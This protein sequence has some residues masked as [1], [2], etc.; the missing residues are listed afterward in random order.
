MMQTMRK[1]AK[2]IFFFVLVTFV[3]FMAYSGIVTS[4]ASKNRAQGGG[5]PP[6]VIGI[7]N[8]TEISNYA[9]DDAY[10]KR[11]QNLTQEDTEP[12]D[13]E[14]EQTRNEIWSNMTTMALL[15]QEAAKHGIVVTDREVANYKRRH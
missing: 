10:R 5:A 12:T 13:A 3:G 1:S 8:E 7:V 4:M 15:D 2:I 6:G 9:F 11:I 14:M